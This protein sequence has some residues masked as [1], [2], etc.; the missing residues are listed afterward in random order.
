MTSARKR[1]KVKNPG[2]KVSRK[3]KNPRRI[4]LA[5]VHP[6]IQ[7][8][9]DRKL[10]LRQNYERIGLVVSLE[11]AAGGLSQKAAGDDSVE[12]AP[13]GLPPIGSKVNLR[14][15]KPVLMGDINAPEQNAI[16]KEMEE[17]ARNAYKE[18]RH[19]SVH[20][21]QFL[22]DLVRKH[23]DDYESMS[24]DKKLNPFLLSAGQ[25]KRK[26]TRKTKGNNDDE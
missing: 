25:L 20:E 16:V 2:S 11:G 17:V 13:S 10:T 18:E 26:L 4:S 24:R 21:E 8:N 12:A 19:A 23:A 5:T 6:I 15:P 22:K 1:R 7:K 3:A 9:W 14:R